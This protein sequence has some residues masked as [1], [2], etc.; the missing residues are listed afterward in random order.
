MV[1]AWSRVVACRDQTASGK[2]AYCDVADT[3]TAV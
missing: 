1:T 3:S 2:Q